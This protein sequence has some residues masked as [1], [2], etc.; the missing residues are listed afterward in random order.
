MDESLVDGSGIS[1]MSLGV[2]LR[3]RYYSVAKNTEKLKQK[4]INCWKK[5]IE[6]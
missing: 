3:P 5:A 6:L 1:S 2:I 4:K